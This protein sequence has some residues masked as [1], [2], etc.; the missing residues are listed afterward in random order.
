M[1]IT[2]VSKVYISKIRLELFLDYISRMANIGSTDIF[3]QI[4]DKRVVSI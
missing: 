4:S 2:A 3:A 1:R